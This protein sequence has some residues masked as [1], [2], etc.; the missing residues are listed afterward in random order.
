M[1]ARVSGLDVARGIAILGTLGTNIWM[2]SHPGGL[3][4]Q[5]GDPIGPGVPAWQV[6]F[7]LVLK[8]VA[9]GKFLGLLTLM[10]GIGMAIQFDSARRKGAAW[11]HGFLW[12]AAVL[13]VDGI[14][15]YLL[16]VE[17]DVL[18]GYAVTGAVVAFVLLTS[19][20]VQRRWMI[21]AASLHV[22]AVA[23]I[24][25]GL[26]LDQ[27]HIGSVVLE[28]NPYRTG[29]WWD[30]FLLRIEMVDVF[31]F[32]AVFILA[33]SVALFLLGA[34]LWRA[35]VFRPEGARLRRTLIIIGAVAL[36]FDLILGSVFAQAFFVVRYLTAPL[37]SLGLLALIAGFTLR[38]APGWW[39]R[40]LGEL[41]RVALSGYVAQNLIASVLFYGWGFGLNGI[42]PALRLPVTLLAWAGI[43]VIILALAHL[44]LRRFSRGPLEAVTARIVASLPVPRPE[45][46]S[47]SAP[48]VPAR[49]ASRS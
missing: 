1:A 36:P 6:P 38:R 22:L 8:Q 21:I 24:T 34:R 18:M 15:H 35:G 13:F 44:W 7:E 45:P 16:V 3:L 23:F 20:A 46:V 33:S 29:S 39:G 49:P 27:A 14:V 43:G 17:F 30:L 25:A 37:V 4:G 42:D 41:G 11:P 31:R 26:V 40:R 12:R 10:F 9:N 28:P 32:E 47:P 48:R 2:F 19:P 5:L